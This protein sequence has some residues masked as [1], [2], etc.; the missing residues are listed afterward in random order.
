MAIS[1]PAQLHPPK[2]LSNKLTLDKFLKEI[3]LAK[4]RYQAGKALFEK[5]IAPTFEELQNI[6]PT[7]IDMIW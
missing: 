2:F 3:H 4:K 7:V 6:P 5:V 1:F